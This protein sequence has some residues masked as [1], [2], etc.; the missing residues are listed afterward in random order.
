MTEIVENTFD[1]SIQ[2]YP[3]IV[4]IQLQMKQLE[5]VGWVCK[6]KKK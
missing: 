1:S 4:K 2:I 3:K 5:L 6:K